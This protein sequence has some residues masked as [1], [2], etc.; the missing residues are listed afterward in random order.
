M[1]NKKT[2]DQNPEQTVNLEENINAVE[3]SAKTKDGVE[4][5]EIKTEDPASAEP[6]PSEETVSE[7]TTEEPE[8]EMADAKVS[9]IFLFLE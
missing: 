8:P 7:T 9:D 1:E 5:Q 4:D 6:A 2:V 3:E